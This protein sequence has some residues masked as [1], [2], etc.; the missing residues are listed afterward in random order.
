MVGNGMTLDQYANLF[1][2]LGGALVVVTLIFLTIQLRQNTI[3]L[4]STTIR[5]NQETTLTIYQMLIE[6]SMMAVILKGMPRPSDLTPLEK[7]KFHA[8]WTVALENY[9]QMYLQMRAGTFDQS[10]FDGWCQVLRNNFLSPGFQLHWNQ[11][12]FIHSLEF[13]DFVEKEIMSLQPTPGME[14]SLAERFEP[15]AV[16]Q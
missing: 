10:L 9:Q 14:K 13:Q 7:G 5:A 11:R 3:A 4:K 15:L 1:E 8:F 6:D 12:K 2:I 16:N